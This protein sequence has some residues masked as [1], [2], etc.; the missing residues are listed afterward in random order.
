MNSILTYFEENHPHSSFDLLHLPTRQPISTD[1]SNPSSERNHDSPIDSHVYP[2]QMFNFNLTNGL[3]QNYQPRKIHQP[4]PASFN[5]FRPQSH[6]QAPVQVLQKPISPL[7]Q[8]LGQEVFRMIGVNMNYINQLIE[9]Q[10]RSKKKLRK[11]LEELR[12]CR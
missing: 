9:S 8:A 1:I 7:C 4:Y 3:I 2:T 12:S 5:Y 6:V 10:E 11:C